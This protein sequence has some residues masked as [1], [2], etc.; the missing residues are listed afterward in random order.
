[1]FADVRLPR[2]AACSGSRTASPTRYYVP[3]DE[4]ERDID[5]LAVGPGPRPRLRDTLRSDGRH[6]PHARPRVP[7]GEPRRDFASPPNVRRARHGARSRSTAGS[8]AGRRS[9]PCRPRCG[10]TRRGRASPSR[11]RPAAAASWPR[12]PRRWRTTSPTASTGVLVP[13]GDVAGWRDLL[14]ELL[15]DEQRRRSLGAGGRRIVEERFNARYMWR[16]GRGR[17]PRSR[18]GLTRLIRRPRC[19]LMSCRK[20][21]RENSSIAQ[22]GRRPTSAPL[23]AGRSGP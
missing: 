15:G 3:G 11:R 10:R 2:G 13:P 7:T 5:L 22:P 21:S 6:R 17:H 14:G 16:R 23:P 20:R 9:S 4:S 8:S 19:S 1:M 18:A 12:T